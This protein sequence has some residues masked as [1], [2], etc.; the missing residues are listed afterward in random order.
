MKNDGEELTEKQ[1]ELCQKY[2]IKYGGIKND[3]DL[4]IEAWKPAVGDTMG[5]AKAGKE[6]HIPF[7][8]VNK[9]P[10]LLFHSSTKDTTKN[11]I[12]NMVRRFFSEFPNKDEQTYEKF[13]EWGQRHLEQ[14]TDIHDSIKKA[15]QSRILYERLFLDVF[16]S[17]GRALDEC[18]QEMFER[19]QVTVFPMNHLGGE[20]ER[21]VVLTLMVYIVHNKLTSNPLDTHINGTPMLL[22]IDEGHRYL[23]EPTTQRERLLINK[24]RETARRGRKVNLGLY[25]VTQNPEDIDGE[26]RK[27]INTKIFLG[28]DPNVVESQEVHVP[29]SFKS[30]VKEFDKGGA[31][32]QAPG[33][34]PVEVKGLPFCVVAHKE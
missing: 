29:Q 11:T 25:V 24:F 9:F 19:G 23:S 33:K 7:R 3:P 1:K 27:Q 8:L 4:S 5:Q 13:S 14:S 6:F 16:D 21:F 17:G 22:S 26:I 12:K 2:G 20:K 10:A 30:R 34:R 28:L 15:I 32:I 31:V 18:S